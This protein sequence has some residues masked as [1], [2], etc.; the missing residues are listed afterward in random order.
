MKFH[1]AQAGS[2]STILGCG[3]LSHRF[4]NGRELHIVYVLR[5][6]T[7]PVFTILTHL[8]LPF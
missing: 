3:I 6:V 2:F 5:S 7:P 1:M 8:S 4:L